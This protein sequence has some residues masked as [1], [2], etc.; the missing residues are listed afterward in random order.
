MRG[1]DE[2]DTAGSELVADAVSLGVVLVFLCFG[3]EGDLSHDLGIF[4]LVGGCSF[5]L[6]LGSEGSEE[7]ESENSVVILDDRALGSVVYLELEHIVN[8]G[9]CKGCV[10]IVCNSLGEVRS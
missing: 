5:F 7:V 8:G 9:N 6:L 4:T 1:V 2:G 10:D 3:A